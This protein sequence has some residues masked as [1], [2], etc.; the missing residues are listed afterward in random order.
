M[1]Q[2]C[3]FWWLRG[4]GV[5]T[6]LCGVLAMWIVAIGT[7]VVTRILDPVNRSTLAAGQIQTHRDFGLWRNCVS[8]AEKREGNA[9]AGTLKTVP[10]TNFH[11]CDRF[12]YPEDN[13]TEFC[14]SFYRLHKFTRAMFLIALVF[15]VGALVAAVLNGLGA[16]PS[17]APGLAIAAFLVTGLVA[18][19]CSW[20]LFQKGF[21]GADSFKKQNNARPGA[22]PVLGIT[23]WLVALIAFIANYVLPSGPHDGH[24]VKR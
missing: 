22:N 13:G 12:R 9:S 19:V 11:F 2:V 16:I 21:C 20:V 7:P 1:P 5:A 6:L 18:F 15:A 23:S 10:D 14:R 24:A 4:F 3:N 8:T 17:V